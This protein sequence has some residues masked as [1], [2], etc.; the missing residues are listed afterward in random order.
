M[1]RYSRDAVNALSHDRQANAGTPTSTTGAR[2]QTR[3]S[4]TRATGTGTTPAGT[5]PPA[6]TVA[7]NAVTGSP[8]DTGTSLPDWWKNAADAADDYDIGTAAYSLSLQASDRSTIAAM[9]ED[10]NGAH[11]ALTA[12]NPALLYGYLTNG[13]QKLFAA[14][15]ATSKTPDVFLLHS[16]TGLDTSTKAVT[17]IEG[18]L[19]TD[20]RASIVV[21]DGDEYQAKNRIAPPAAAFEQYVAADGDK[22]V[23]KPRN[24][25]NGT[26]EKWKAG[27]LAFIPPIL[28]VD[29]VQHRH[30][31]A[32]L[33]GTIQ[34]RLTELR[35]TPEQTSTMDTVL[36]QLRALGTQRNLSAPTPSEPAAPQPSRLQGRMISLY[37]S[38]DAGDRPLSRTTSKKV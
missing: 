6:G 17:F 8:G 35:L 5:T 24:T 33:Y 1:T 37:E 12:D 22:F 31:V 11:T 28:G 32:S 18:E 36:R 19:G 23:P 25:D 13:E 15:D 9:V 3:S 20:N 2:A 7:P 34:D 27:A 10:T 21:I 38:M 4:T 30:T 29:L 26:A 14:V 16:P